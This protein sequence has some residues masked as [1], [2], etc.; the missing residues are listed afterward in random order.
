LRAKTERR[1][2]FAPIASPNRT[3]MR[4]AAPFSTGSTPGY[5]RSTRLACT[6]GIAP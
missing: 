6:F 2:I 4:T 5:P 1:A 3:A